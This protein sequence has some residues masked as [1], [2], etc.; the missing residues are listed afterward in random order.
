MSDDEY[1]FDVN[2]NTESILIKVFYGQQPKYPVSMGQAEVPIRKRQNGSQFRIH[3][4]L[5]M[6]KYDEADHDYVPS[7]LTS[8]HAD[9]DETRHNNVAPEIS[10]NVVS[11]LAAYAYLEMAVHVVKESSIAL[12]V[13]DDPDDHLH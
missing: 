4:P 3:V 1:I 2:N 5:E 10:F 13:N 8:D 12:S 9:H 7:N 11:P 6:P